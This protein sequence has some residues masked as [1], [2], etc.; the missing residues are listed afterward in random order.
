MKI[1]FLRWPIYLFLLFILLCGVP[2]IQA[3][4]QVVIDGKTASLDTGI[5][6]QAGQVISIK[7]TGLVNPCYPGGGWFSPDGTGDV[8]DIYYEFAL[9]NISAYSLIG[10]IAGPPFDNPGYFPPGGTLLDGGGTGY[11]GL[12]FVGSNFQGIAPVSGN[13]FLGINDCYYPDN[14]GSFT[15]DI[16]IIPA[17]GAF[18]LG[19]IGVGLV[20]WLHRRRTL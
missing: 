6:F 1:Q 5:H 17:P 12:G 18:L 15:A 3:Y 19:G 7:A 20:G 13:L 8:I 16:S 10:A 9:L 14:F 2:C 4:S 11:Q